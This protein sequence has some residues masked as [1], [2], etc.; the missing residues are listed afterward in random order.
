M[1]QIRKVL[2]KKEKKEHIAELNR[3]VVISK[4]KTYFVDDLA[5]DFHT[6]D[7]FVSKADLKKKDGS[8]IAT[9][10]GKKFNIFTSSFMDDYKRIAREAQIISVKDIAAIIAKTG[11]NKNSIVV[12]AGA[13]SGALACFLAHICKEVITYDIREDFLK[14]VKRNKE[15]LNL[16]NLKI[17]NKDIYKGIDE[18]NVD[19][20]TLDL[21]SPWNA[22]KSA[23]AA[24]RVGGFLVSYSPS[25]PQMMDFVNAINKDDRFIH[26]KTIEIIEREWE[27]DERKVRP[28]TKGIGH[29]GFLSF[30]RKIK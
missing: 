4:E 28:M 9:N 25:V 12:D 10:T 13:G 17:K 7:G 3:D 2:I 18:K 30:A 6:A 24:L 5:K 29:T 20:I 8:E 14:I 26:V 19:L 1:K 16:N 27:V 21:P 11:I 15:F 23:Y 22:I